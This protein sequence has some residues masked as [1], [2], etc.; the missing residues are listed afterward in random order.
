MDKAQILIVEDESIVAFDLK[1]KLM[2]LGYGVPALAV[3]GMEAIA[4]SAG[5][6]PDLVLMDIRLQGDMDG[7]EAAEHIRTQLN[8]PVIYLTAYADETTLQRA[9]ISEPYGYLLKP[10]AERELQ[11][12]IEMALYRHHLEQKLEQ[13]EQWLSAVLDSIGEAIIATDETGQ[14]KFMN[15]VA[16]TLTGWSQA[17]SLGRDLNE[18]FNLVVNQGSPHGENPARQVLGNEMAAELQPPVR[19]TTKGGSGIYIEE[20]FAPI[21]AGQ[22]Q[23]SGT[24]L[25]FRDVT[26]RR[27][28]EDALARSHE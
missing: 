2:R 26:D 7:I 1:K 5:I 24:V 11:I 21:R 27:R 15:P 25:A 12:S 9:K 14:I 10:L 23:I 13:S 8:L 3:S 18:V 6:R 4:L 28:L 17:E 22:G 19:L 20:S 16:E